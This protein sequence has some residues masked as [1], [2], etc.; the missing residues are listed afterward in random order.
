MPLNDIVSVVTVEG[1]RI[2]PIPGVSTTLLGVVNYQ[3]R[4]L[5]VAELSQLLGLGQ[6]LKKLELR[7]SLAL[8]VVSNTSNDSTH[9]SSQQQVGCIVSALKGIVKINSEQLKL[10]PAE[11]PLLSSFVSKVA[12][13]EEL[14]IAILNLN[15]IFASLML[16]NS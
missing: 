3:G 6:F 14:P 13:V 1:K 7:R 8:V 16:D 5:W 10:V 4:L 12:K 9:E 11:F 2:C 15:A